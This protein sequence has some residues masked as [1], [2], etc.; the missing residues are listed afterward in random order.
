MKRVSKSPRRTK[1]KS[2]AAVRCSAWLGGGLMAIADVNAKPWQIAK[3]EA[4]VDVLCVWDGKRMVVVKSRY[5]PT[6]QVNQVLQRMLASGQRGGGR[7]K[8][9]GRGALS[10][11]RTPHL[12]PPR[13]DESPKA[14]NQNTRRRETL[15]VYPRNTPAKGGRKTSR[16]ETDTQRSSNVRAMRAYKRVEPPNDPSSATRPTGGDK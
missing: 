4:V 5:L 6:Q 3:V 2:G 14:P 8:A 7:S 12:R 15:A 16:T 11:R 13:S 10:M 9:T 1:R